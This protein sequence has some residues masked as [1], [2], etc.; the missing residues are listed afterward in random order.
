MRVCMIV[1]LGRCGGGGAIERVG[2]IAVEPTQRKG[3]Q[4]RGSPETTVTKDRGALHD[5]APPPPP[6]RTPPQISYEDANVRILL[7]DGNTLARLS[8]PLIVYR[9]ELLDGCPRLN[10]LVIVLLWGVS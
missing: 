7:F 6:P 5:T 3:R 8:T 2:C 4:T 10:T 1:Q 9:G